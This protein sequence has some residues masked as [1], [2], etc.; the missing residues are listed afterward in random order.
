MKTIRKTLWLL[1]AVVT[2]G[3]ACH[4]AACHRQRHTSPLDGLY[5]RY[6]QCDGLAAALVRGKGIPCDNGDSIRVDM[7]ILSAD[8]GNAWQRL[9]AD[10]GIPEP[11]QPMQQLIDGG[12]DIVSVRRYENPDAPG[13]NIRIASYL[14]RQVSIIHAASEDEIT[15]VRHHNMETNIGQ[16][17][18]S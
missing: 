1:A 5:A 8:D 4:L 13:A 14:N 7:L 9:S 11:V 17:K 12:N 10:F 15:L 18:K 3:A 16:T 2:I 6:S